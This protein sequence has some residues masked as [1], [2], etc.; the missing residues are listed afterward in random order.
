M[1]QN[2]TDDEAFSDGFVGVSRD[3]LENMHDTELAEWHAGWK[4]GTAKHIL[5]E[6]EWQRRLSLRQLHEQFKLDSRLADANIQAMKF[7]A[8][9]GVLGAL[10]GAGIGAYV[11]FKTAGNAQG[12]PLENRPQEQVATETSRGH[13]VPTKASVSATG[14]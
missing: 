7:A 4:P 6:K 5:A 10:A 8:I 12:S 2:Q 3:E 14:K 1:T 13:S 11:T 9:L